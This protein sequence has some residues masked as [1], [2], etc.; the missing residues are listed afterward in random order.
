MVGNGVV[1]EMIVIFMLLIYCYLIFMFN[2]MI[3]KERIEVWESKLRGYWKKNILVEGLRNVKVLSV[4][5]VF[6]ISEE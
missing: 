1:L 4:C 2:K 6:G 5:K 3:F